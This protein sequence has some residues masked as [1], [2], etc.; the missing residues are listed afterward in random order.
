MREARQGHRI[1]GW[2]LRG[3][4][5]RIQPLQQMLA[6]LRPLRIGIQPDGV[7]PSVPMRFICS[8]LGMAIGAIQANQSARGLVG[9]VHK[10]TF[11]DDGLGRGSG[12]LKA[13]GESQGREGRSEPTPCARGG[14]VQGATVK[15]TES[16]ML[17][18]SL[19]LASAPSAMR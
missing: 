11:G 12:F 6:A 4:G 15:A 10:A 19:W 17:S 8:A 2:I 3:R 1:D 7:A 9:A 13:A 14:P 16:V 18:R 5:G